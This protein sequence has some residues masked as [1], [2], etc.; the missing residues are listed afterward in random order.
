MWGYPMIMRMTTAG[1]QRLLIEID[2]VAIIMGT[3]TVGAM[4]CNNV[5]L[6]ST[7]HTHVATPLERMREMMK[8]IQ[9]VS[10]VNYV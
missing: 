6:P 9:P 2:N 4:W 3:R 1:I 10:L 7:F 8:T 5:I